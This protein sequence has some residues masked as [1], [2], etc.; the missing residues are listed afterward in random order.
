MEIKIKF[1]RPRLSRS[2]LNKENLLELVKKYNLEN[3]IELRSRTGDGYTLIP[4]ISE[5]GKIPQIPGEFLREFIFLL[6]EGKDPWQ[7]SW[8]FFKIGPPQTLKSIKRDIES[9]NLHCNLF[10]QAHGG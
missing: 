9:W 1:W 3:K 2:K 5:Q 7:R 4:I 8:R 10:W 6:F